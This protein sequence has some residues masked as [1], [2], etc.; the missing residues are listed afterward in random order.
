LDGGATWNRTNG[1]RVRG[2]A[3]DPSRPK[4]ILLATDDAGILRS[5]DG[6]L[7]FGPANQGLCTR[8]LSSLAES[9]AGIVTSIIGEQ[10]KWSMLQLLPQSSDWLA[11]REVAEFREIQ[12]PQPLR[13]RPPIYTVAGQTLV[14][15]MDG[16][17]NWLRLDAPT[18][19]I[20]VLAPAASRKKIIAAAMGGLYTASENGRNWE[21]VSAPVLRMPVRQLVP[22]YESAFAAIGGSQ[23]LLSRDGLDWTIATPSPGKEVLGMTA[24]GANCLLAATSAGLRRSEDF[25]STWQAAGGAIGASSMQAIARDP[26]QEGV[27]YAAGFGVVYESRDDAQSWHRVL[28]EGPGIDPIVQLLPALDRLFVLTATRGVFV[29]DRSVRAWQ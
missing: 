28:P 20:A 9:Q 7:H 22:L 5:T 4:R 2:I 1:S 11:I 24:C 13:T 27:Y 14:R 3:F 17:R 21:K 10:T 29:L 18:G 12:G 26:I 6:G 23:V 15:S 19:L 25:G 16:G 8:H